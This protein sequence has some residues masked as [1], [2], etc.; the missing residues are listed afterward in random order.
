MEA[1]KAR[2]RI[3][4]IKQE[5]TFVTLY[6]GLLVISKLICVMSMLLILPLEKLQYE[7]GS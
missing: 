7:L 3:I 4:S 1:L 6:T 5:L 2:G